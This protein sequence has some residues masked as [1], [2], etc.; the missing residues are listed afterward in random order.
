MGEPAGLFLGRRGAIGPRRRAAGPEAAAGSSLVL[1]R[2]PSSGDLFI[3]SRMAVQLLVPQTSPAPANVSQHFTRAADKTRPIG[4]DSEAAPCLMADP[5]KRNRIHFADQ[6]R[7]VLSMLA[8]ISGI[9]AK[10]VS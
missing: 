3:A 9:D 7:P 6:I 8:R 1:G 5:P 4:R 10:K 2:A